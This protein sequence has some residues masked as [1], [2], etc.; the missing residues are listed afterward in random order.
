MASPPSPWFSFLDGNFMLSN[1][2]DVDPFDE[3]LGSGNTIAPPPPLLR[4]G[5][6]VPDLSYRRDLSYQTDLMHQPDPS[7]QPV[8]PVPAMPVANIGSFQQQPNV[9]YVNPGTFQYPLDVLRTQQ[10]Q[11]SSSMSAPVVETTHPAPDFGPPLTV[12]HNTNMTEEPSS[13]ATDAIGK[14]VH[15]R[16]HF[17]GHRT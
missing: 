16:D 7:Y 3:T 17:G 15:I 13:P 1:I 10:A 6:P 4:V 11:S 2:A 5:C 8:R 12:H 9:P 14:G